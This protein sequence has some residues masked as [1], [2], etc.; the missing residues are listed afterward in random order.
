MRTE[1]LFNI[2]ETK[3]VAACIEYLL[4]QGHFVWRNNTGATSNVYRAND[5]SFRTRYWKSGIKGSS[6][7]IGV[8]KDGRFIAVECKKFPFK[9]KPEQLDFLDKVRKRGGIALVAYSIKDCE[10]GGL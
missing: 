1:A 7:I 9:A 6:D 4:R 3:V 2:S 5:G 8:S 10:D